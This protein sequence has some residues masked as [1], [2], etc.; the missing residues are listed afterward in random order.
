MDRRKTARGRD[1]DAGAVPAIDPKAGM[2]EHE[3]LRKGRDRLGLPEDEEATVPKRERERSESASLQL[4][5]E[6]D[7][8]V[9]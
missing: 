9:A 4:V 5:R 2:F 6:V 7:E 3:V 8:D 1:E